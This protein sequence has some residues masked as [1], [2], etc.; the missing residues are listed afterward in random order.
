M[1]V[2]PSVPATAS[3]SPKASVSG[4]CLVHPEA[5]YFNVGHIGNDQI[6]DWAW[7]M[8][9]DEG[10]ARRALAGVV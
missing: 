2:L 5:A 7:R 4:F 3:T 10:E 6:A 9:L 8:V 1:V